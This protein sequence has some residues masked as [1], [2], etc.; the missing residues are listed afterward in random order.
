[1]TLTQN[2][3]N[4]FNFQ[5]TTD[6][7]T[8]LTSVPVEGQYQNVAYDAQ[9]LGDGIQTLDGSYIPV[10]SSL[11]PVETIDIEK[12]TETVRET[13]KKVS[14]VTFLK[15]LSRYHTKI[16]ITGQD[17]DYWPHLCVNRHL[18]LSVCQTK[19]I[20]VNC[21]NCSNQKSDWKNSYTLK[22]L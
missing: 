18:S 14:W 7:L 17:T 19:N 2:I 15:G 16:R 5:G 4:Y 12:D 11:E 20:W 22:V 1:M 6:D 10:V 13:P 3:L 21:S 8:N 9:P